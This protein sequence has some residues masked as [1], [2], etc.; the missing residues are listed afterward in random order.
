MTD[1]EGH[2]NTGAALLCD[3][4]VFDGDGR[5]NI[6]VYCMVNRNLLKF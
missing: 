2:R 6:S 4:L 1:I 3:G 5:E